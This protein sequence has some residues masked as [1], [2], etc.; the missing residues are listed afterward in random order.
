MDIG[1]TILTISDP[2]ETGR[3]LNTAHSSHQ[4]DDRLEQVQDGISRINNVDIR[5]VSRPACGLYSTV[6]P[7]KLHIIISCEL[8]FLQM[9]T[10]LSANETLFRLNI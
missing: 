5:F 4:H 2:K 6:A 10:S 9:P 7:R 8:Y 1:I 3:L